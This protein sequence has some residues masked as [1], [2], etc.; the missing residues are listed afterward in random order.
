VGSDAEHWQQ[1]TNALLRLLGAVTL[2]PVTGVFDE[3]TEQVTRR[4]QAWAQI[5]TDGVVGPVTLS[6]MAQRL[7][8][9]AVRNAQASHGFDPVGMTGAADGAAVWAPT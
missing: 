9:H 8:H 1:Q 2:L 7:T 5:D 4:F 6:A 3:Q